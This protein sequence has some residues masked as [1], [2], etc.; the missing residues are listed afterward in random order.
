[1]DRLL[2]MKVRSD[3][4]VAQG[5]FERVL[6]EV[7]SGTEAVAQSHRLHVALQR[8]GGPE[9]TALLDEGKR[10]ASLEFL[11]LVAPDGR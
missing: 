8:G 9:L 5:Y 4:A 2:I 1:I 3:L 11:N 6:A 7:A 10:R